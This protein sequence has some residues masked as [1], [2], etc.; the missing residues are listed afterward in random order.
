MR[1]A[2][3][4]AT[5]LEAYAATGLL[6]ACVFVAFGIKQ[7]DPLV[8]GSSIGFRLIVLPGVAALWPVM[9][10][11]WIRNKGFAK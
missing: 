6:F 2:E 9:L 1:A 4:L 10:R 3:L 7:V 8:R 5:A 11:R